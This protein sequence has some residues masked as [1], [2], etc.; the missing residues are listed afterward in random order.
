MGQS[1][2]C[3]PWAVSSA[4]VEG[5]NRVLIAADV[6]ASGIWLISRRAEDSQ[7]KLSDLLGEQL[8]M[9]LKIWNDSA[10]VL[11][12]GRVR[13]EERAQDEEAAFYLKAQELASKVQAKLGT[14]WE[15][16]WNEG[17]HLCWSWIEPPQS[18]RS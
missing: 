10:N 14:G 13:Q 17:P 2:S 18:R 12:G 8:T 6:E 11:F 7:R 4:T 15:V 3:E 5:P 9:D 16:L 1:F